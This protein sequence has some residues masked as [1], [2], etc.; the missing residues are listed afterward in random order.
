[1]KAYGERRYS[2]THSFP[3]HYLETNQLHASGTLFQEKSPQYP[4]NRKLGRPHSLLGA[5][6]TANRKAIQ[7][8]NMNV[9]YRNILCCQYESLLLI[10]KIVNL[11]IQANKCWSQASI[12]Q[13]SNVGPINSCYVR[14]PFVI[15][16][17]PP[18]QT[19]QTLWIK[20]QTVPRQT[21]HTKEVYLSMLLRY[22]GVH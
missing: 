6:P 21:H 3:Q 1:M 7:E 11:Q 16:A 10:F 15:F 18:Q 5:A 19:V 9:C 20:T 14:R 12:C 2:S 8:H 17:Q 4:S 13:C 22:D